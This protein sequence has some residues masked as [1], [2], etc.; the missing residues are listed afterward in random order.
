MRH[1]EEKDI[2]RFADGNISKAEREAFL[3][4]FSQCESCLKA[5]TDTLKFAEERKKN[6][7]FLFFP[8]TVNISVYPYLQYVGL[9]FK[10]KLVVPALAF[11]ILLLVILSPLIRKTTT[12]EANTAKL[13]YIEECIMKKENRENYGLFPSKNLIN[14]AIRAGF[15]T[16]DL[17]IVLHS[18]SKK[19][20][21]IKITRMLTAELERIV[22]DEG[23]MDLSFLRLEEMSKTN[24]KKMALEIRQMLE[25]KSLYQLY[26]FGR[27]IERSI[28]AT[29]EKKTPKKNELEKYLQIVRKYHLP[30]SIP[31]KLEEIKKTSGAAEKRDLWNDVKEIF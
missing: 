8:I 14:S 5:Y 2:A 13:K 9:F 4:H 3:D 31:G 22:E 24:F 11:L 19:E 17:E 7:W 6:R 28:L 20:L 27:F 10:R 12:N 1:I 29:F 18:G 21:E 16:E 26:Q 25:T 30:K 15:F 23:K